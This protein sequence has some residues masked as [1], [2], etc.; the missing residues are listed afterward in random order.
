MTGA[1]AWTGGY[2]SSAKA[3]EINVEIDTAEHNNWDS[4]ND[5]AAV[6]TGVMRWTATVT[7]DYDTA[8][9]MTTIGTSGTLTLTA[10]GPRACTRP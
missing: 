2:S 7:C 8:T 6:T 3:W 1:V 9:A 10:D 4:A 5:W